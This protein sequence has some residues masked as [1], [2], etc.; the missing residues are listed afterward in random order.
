[1]LALFNS[2]PHKQAL[3]QQVALDGFAFWLLLLLKAKPALQ[4]KLLPS[5]LYTAQVRVTVMTLVAGPLLA[6]FCS[7]LAVTV[8]L[9]VNDP[10]AVAFTTSVKLLLPPAGMLATVQVTV[11]P[12]AVQPAA[13]A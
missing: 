12:A 10:G 6:V 7:S 13:A 5:P 8:A 11:W 2:T 4:L 9:A 3:T 1:M